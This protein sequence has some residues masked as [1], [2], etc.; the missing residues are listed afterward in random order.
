MG[1]DGDVQ[2]GEW[3]VQEEEP[4]KEAGRSWRRPQAPGLCAVP[5]A[6]GEMTSGR[7]E[8][9]WCL[10]SPRGGGLRGDLGVEARL[11][12]LGSYRRGAGERAEATPVVS[13]EGRERSGARGGEYLLDT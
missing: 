9:S 8:T 13:R 4:G 2:A 12:D 6:L 1:R 3:A 5:K 11:E 7:N 10:L